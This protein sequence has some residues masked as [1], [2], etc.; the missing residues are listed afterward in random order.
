MWSL[1]DLVPVAA[2]S[3]GCFTNSDFMKP[4]PSRSTTYLAKDWVFPSNHPG[5]EDMVPC[6]VARC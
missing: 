6:P 1:L 4:F 3:T 5:E 2:H